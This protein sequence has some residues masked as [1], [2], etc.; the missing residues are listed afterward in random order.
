MDEE[1]ALYVSHIPSRSSLS[2]LQG[3]IKA[4]IAHGRWLQ[5][6][7]LMNMHQEETEK[8]A[9]FKD[10]LGFRKIEISQGCA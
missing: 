10:Y 6:R 4:Y 5:A 3:S 7:W 2:A 8:E 9:G 1:Y